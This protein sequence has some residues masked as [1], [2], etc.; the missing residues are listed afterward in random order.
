V[1]EDPFELYQDNV[2]QWRW[3]LGA[4]NGQLLASSGEAFASEAN[5]ERSI[6]AVRRTIASLGGDA[7]PKPKP[8][9]KG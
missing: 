7:R 8:K 2:G 1:P 3:R 9:A 5:A 6:R 4:R